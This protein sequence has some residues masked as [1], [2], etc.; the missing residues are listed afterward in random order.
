MVT[1]YLVRRRIEDGRIF[2]DLLSSRG[3]DVTVAAWVQA[4]QSEGEIWFL[5]I[6][7]KNVN[8]SGLAGAY[9]EAYRIHADIEGTTISASD[10]KLIGA[11]NPISADLL[12]IRE[13]YPEKPVGPPLVF[14]IGSMSI[15][16]VYVYDASDIVRQAFT[17]KYYREGQSNRWRS[18]VRRGELLRG[19]RASGAVAYTSARWGAEAAE[20][21]NFAL[22]SVLLELDPRFVEESIIG[23]PDVR[24]V[25]DD[26]AAQA[27][28]EM[29]K[30]HHPDAEIRHENGN[31]A[32]EI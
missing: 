6:G 11:D 19:V 15:G 8:D 12:R 18:T 14:R 21:E 16:T 5:Y 24:Q 27:A 26:Q 20:V 2:I 22:V 3:F 1:D 13:E 4:S 17:V 9:R 10:V 30:S 31:V 29:F 7:S 25:L 28:D 23:S 32:Q